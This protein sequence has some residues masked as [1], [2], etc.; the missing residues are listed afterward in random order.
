[1][2]SAHFSGCDWAH[3]FSPQRTVK[4][5]GCGPGWAGLR[6]SLPPPL[7]RRKGRD[8]PLPPPPRVGGGEEGGGGGWRIERS[9]RS[10]AAAHSG[11]GDLVVFSS[12]RAGVVERVWGSGG[13][14]AASA[15]R[16]RGLRS[17]P[18]RAGHGGW[19]WRLGG[20]SPPG[21]VQPARGRALAR[22]PAARPLARSPLPPAPPS[23]VPPPRTRRL[24]LGPAPR[25][26]APQAC[27]RLPVRHAP[28]LPPSIAASRP[29]GP[30]RPP[31]LRLVLPG[32]HRGPGPSLAARPLARPVRRCQ[33]P[34]PRR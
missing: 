11:E 4:P 12:D 14:A 19:G 22:A 18:G 3:A 9:S 8:A 28:S 29:A 27:E 25:T 20:R 33:R 1:M 7:S 34:G 5:I 30:R 32:C 2:T 10:G 6:R 23:L 26:M 24:P 21:L 17:G 16:L 15:P 31:R 13:A